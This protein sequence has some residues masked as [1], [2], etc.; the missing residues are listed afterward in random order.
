MHARIPTGSVAETVENLQTFDLDALQVFIS[1]LQDRAR[2]ELSKASLC[3][4]GGVPHCFFCG[5][6][7]SF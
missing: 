5:L 7:E 4:S 3:Q 1:T 6:A 2:T